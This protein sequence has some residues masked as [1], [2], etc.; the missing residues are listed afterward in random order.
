MKDQRKKFVRV[1]RNMF[2]EIKTLIDCMGFS[3]FE[4]P[5]EA[6]ELCA[7]LCSTNQVYG[8]MSEDSDMFVY[9][10]RKVFKKLDFKNKT[11]LMYDYNKILKEINITDNNF[12]QLCIISG[13]DYNKDSKGIFYYYKIYNKY[14]NSKFYLSLY[15]FFIYKKYNFDYNILFNVY[16]M[17]TLNKFLK[18]D[19]N[20]KFKNNKVKKS[21]LRNLLLKYNFIFTN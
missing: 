20:C 3:Y 19:Y 18:K 14:F 21:E 12:K 17:Y 7:W 6:D 1:S 4:A 2:E 13:T 11:I 10:C 5:C 16:D 15:D 8:C 9:G